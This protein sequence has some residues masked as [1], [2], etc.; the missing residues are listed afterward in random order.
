LLIL[1]KSLSHVQSLYRQSLPSQ[2]A[3]L[4][5]RVSAVSP[6]GSSYIVHENGK[7]R[8]GHCGSFM[9]RMNNSNTFSRSSA[10]L[11][12]LVILRAKHSKITQ[13]M[14]SLCGSFG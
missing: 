2:F 8:A 10:F 14:T 12:K 9:I 11:D 7:Q 6:E 4:V 5:P 13:K 1:Q 3:Q